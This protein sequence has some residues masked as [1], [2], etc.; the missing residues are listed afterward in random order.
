MSFEDF[1]KFCQE[2]SKKRAGPLFP[3]LASPVRP[4]RISELDGLTGAAKYK[5]IGEL[6][7]QT[8]PEYKYFR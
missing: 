3:S 4:I 7:E 5:K 6:I 8:H 2:S 1:V